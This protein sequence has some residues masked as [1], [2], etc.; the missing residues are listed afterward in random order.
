[1]LKYL[2]TGTAINIAQVRNALEG[3]REMAWVN[4]GGQIMQKK[5]LDKLRAD[6]GTGKITSWQDIHK[7]Y[8]SLWEKYT[9]DKQK[10]AFAT[11]CDLN[12][13][14]DL[15]GE[16]WKVALQKAALI[17]QYICDQVYISRKKDYDNPFRH[18]T[19]RNNDELKSTIGTVDDNSFILQVQQET[20]E[21]KKLIDTMMKS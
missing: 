15:T 20:D 9:V 6:I 17:Q 4:L 2:Q 18:S 13:K 3:K 8:D 7:R 11:L 12:G 21:M 5:D 19:F 10:H 16:D 1:L 14:S